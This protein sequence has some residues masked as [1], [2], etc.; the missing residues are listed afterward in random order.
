MRGNHRKRFN[1]ALLRRHRDGIFIRSA[2]VREGLKISA[3]W[4]EHMTASVLRKVLCREYLT[5]EQKTT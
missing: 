4:L 5:A 1:S 2:I 3:S